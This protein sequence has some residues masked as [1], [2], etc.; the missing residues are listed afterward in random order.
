M[1]VLFTGSV[2]VGKIVATAAA[3]TLTPTTLEV[4]VINSYCTATAAQTPAR[5]EEPSHRLS[6]CRHAAHGK[7]VVEYQAYWKR[8]GLR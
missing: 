3:K 2:K 7:A 6:L 5:R 4:S 8:T 1:S